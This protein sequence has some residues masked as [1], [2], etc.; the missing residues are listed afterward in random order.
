MNNSITPGAIT[1]VIN[2][3]YGLEDFSYR[4]EE[5]EIEQDKEGKILRKSR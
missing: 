1:P 2:L 4:E 3:P 5:P